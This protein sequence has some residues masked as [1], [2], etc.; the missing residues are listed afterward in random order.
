MVLKS[1]MCSGA[2]CRGL[3]QTL[4][5]LRGTFHR[6]DRQITFAPLTAA[7]EAACGRPAAAPTAAVAASGD[8]PAVLGHRAC[9]IT[10]YVHFVH[11]AQTDAASQKWR[12]AARAGSKPCAPRRRRVAPPA[13]RT[14]LC[15]Q[16]SVARALHRSLDHV[17]Y[18]SSGGMLDVKSNGVALPAFAGSTANGGLDDM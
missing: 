17:S 10:R 7:G 1:K 5:V 15:R 8:S 9:R 6:A 16:R 18:G 13:S 12:R 14:R 2:W 3:P 11:C 4:D